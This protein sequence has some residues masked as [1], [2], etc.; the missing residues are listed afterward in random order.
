[1]HNFS[2]LVL[3]DWRQFGEVDLQ[4]HPRL[5]VLTGANATGKS[6]I[7]GVLARHFNWLHQYST[8]PVHF[9][10]SRGAWSSVSRRRARQIVARGATEVG[11]LTYGSGVDTAISVSTDESKKRVQY[12]LVMPK[13]QEVDGIYIN[14]HR[15]IHGTYTK[16][17]NIPASVGTPEDILQDYNKELHNRWAGAF[18]KRS[19]QLALK[20]ALMAAALLG[21]RGNPYVDADPEAVE[22]WEGFHG[23]LRRLLPDS[24][25]FNRLKVRMPDIVLE[26][27]SGDFIIDEASGGLSAIIEI[28]WQIYLKSTVCK[29]FSVL[30]D[31]PENHLHP[32]LQRELMPALLRSFPGAQ[33]IVATHSPFVVTAEPSSFVYA[34]RYDPV[35]GEVGTLLL[36]YAN[37]AAAAEE[38]LVEVLGLASTSPIWAD[39]KFREIMDDFQGGPVDQDRL[40]QLRRRLGQSGLAKDFPDALIRIMEQQGGHE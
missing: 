1:M 21:G 6:T 7:L 32:S 37:K 23:V 29:H 19:P 11:R 40:L 28:A 26:T 3:H 8:A 38:T 35:S 31:E 9:Q 14:S 25:G 27:D 20:Q 34:L 12:D 5:T 16:V 33:F 13:Q 36:D 17:D 24:I 15:S 4:F 30:F 2:R 18:S 39:R 10:D 22:L